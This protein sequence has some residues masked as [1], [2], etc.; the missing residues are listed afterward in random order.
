MPDAFHTIAIPSV[1]D[2]TGAPAL[3]ARCKELAQTNSPI[4][5]DASGVERITTPALQVLV[6][7]LKKRRTQ[8]FATTIAPQ[9]EHFMTTVK[10][11]GLTSFFE[12]EQAHG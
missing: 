1:L 2:I 7:L 10:T 9:S 12:Q 4:A 5:I 3:L 8:G 6:A 11:L